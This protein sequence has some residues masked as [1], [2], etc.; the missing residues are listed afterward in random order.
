MYGKC[1]C[2]STYLYLSDFFV[3]LFEDLIGSLTIGILVWLF[4]SF[5]CWKFEYWQTL[6]VYEI[7]EEKYGY[8]GMFA[9]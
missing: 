4:Q 1:I 9:M 7:A 8:I 5:R 3:N 6:A 2:Y